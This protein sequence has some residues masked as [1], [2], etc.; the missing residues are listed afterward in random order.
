MRILR[1]GYKT[2]LIQN[3]DLFELQN[4]I[5]VVLFII[6][7]RLFHFGNSD[8]PPPFQVPTIC[9]FRCLACRVTL[10]AQERPILF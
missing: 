9:I 4:T 10:N 6:L 7:V 5:H 2:N 1:S 8:P 3:I